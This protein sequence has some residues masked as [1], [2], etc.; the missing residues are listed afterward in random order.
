MYTYGLRLSMSHFPD[1]GKSANSDAGKSQLPGHVWLLN[2]PVLIVCQLI[3]LSSSGPN[4]DLAR[5][6]QIPSA[7]LQAHKPPGP[8]RPDI[9]TIIHYP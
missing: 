9:F 7:L 5:S 3:T 1:S 2:I 4:R 6:R 8:P